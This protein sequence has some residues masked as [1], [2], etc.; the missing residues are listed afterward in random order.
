M[1]QLLFLF[2]F[3]ATI[4]SASA[5]DT[6]DQSYLRALNNTETVGIEADMANQASMQQMAQEFGLDLNYYSPTNADTAQ[7]TGLGSY[8]NATSNNQSNANIPIK[9]SSNQTPN[10]HSISGNA[11]FDSMI[12]NASD[13]KNLPDWDKGVNVGLNARKYVPLDSALKYNDPKLGYNAQDQ[14]KMNT[15]VSSDDIIPWGMLGLIIAFILALIL[16]GKKKQNAVIGKPRQA[17]PI[18]EFTQLQGISNNYSIQSQQLSVIEQIKQWKELLDSGAIT[19]DE[20]DAQ[21]K[22]LL[23]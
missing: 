2:A 1:K 15:S 19:Q 23:G 10:S 21:K 7:S 9:P 14:N 5:Q 22:K 3:A 12:R 20:Y 18:K 17:V 13:P 8:N 16:K 6:D 4:M 11:T